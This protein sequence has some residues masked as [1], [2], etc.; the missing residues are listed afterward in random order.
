[1]IMCKYI[2]KV[3]AT[4]AVLRDYNSMVFIIENTDEFIREKI[5][6]M[7]SMKSAEIDGMPKVHDPSAFENKMVKCIDDVQILKNRYIQAK[8]YMHWFRPAFEQLD[9][10]EQHVLD[11]CFMRDDH[12]N[13]TETLV[14]ELSMTKSP[15]YR[16]K[17]RAVKHLSVLL[18]G[19]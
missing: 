7:F 6:R 2:D 12:Y 16:W 10:K 17:N 19:M 1:M 4:E 18:Y 11:I 5:D 9:S 15:A 13:V 8:E 3:A 14:D